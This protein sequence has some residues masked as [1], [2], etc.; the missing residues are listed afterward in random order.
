MCDERAL[1][2]AGF[3]ALGYHVVGAHQRGG[4]GVAI[5][6]KH[7]P[8]QV[9]RGIDGA[10]GR[11]REPRLVTATIQ[12]VRMH[13]LYAPNGRKVATPEHSFKLAWF[14]LLEAVLEVEGFD[15]RPV[16]VLG[17]LNIAP[18]DADVWDAARYR[19]RNLTSPPERQAFQRLIELGL[20]DVVRAAHGPGPLSTWWNRRGDFYDSDRGW[21]LDHILANEQLAKRVR[22]AYVDRAVRGIEGGSDHAPV[23]AVIGESAD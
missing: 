17:D 1:R 7:E 13:S 4:A 23:V 8:T 22:A 16:V 9:C 19:S 2:T 6:S 20:H 14:R 11:F 10:A 15:V 18:T 3:A 12:G 21:R 5:A